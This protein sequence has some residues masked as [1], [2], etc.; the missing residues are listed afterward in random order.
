[1]QKPAVKVTEITFAEEQKGYPT[2][3]TNIVCTIYYEMTTEHT[4]Y[5]DLC[6]TGEAENYP[7]AARDALSNLDWDVYLDAIFTEDEVAILKVAQQIFED[8]RG[9]E[10]ENVLMQRA[11]IQMQPRVESNLVYMLA[12]NHLL[13]R[14]DEAYTTTFCISELGRF[15]VESQRQFNKNTPE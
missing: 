14:H 9:W 1:M 5:A 11:K 15:I 13:E 8:D 6:V 2:A 4:R 3:K 12:A 10:T 7:E